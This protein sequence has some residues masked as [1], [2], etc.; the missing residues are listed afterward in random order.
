V[1]PT[2]I[3]IGEDFGPS[4]SSIPIP[5]ASARSR[6]GGL[7]QSLAW[8]AFAWCRRDRLRPTRAADRHRPVSISECAA[9]TRS[10]WCA[11]RSIGARWPLRR[12]DLQIHR[13]F[14]RR[15]MRADGGDVD[16]FS[17]YR[18]G[19]LS[20][21]A[22]DQRLEVF[23]GTTEMRPLLALNERVPAARQSRG[24]D[25]DFLRARSARHHRRGMSDMARR[26]ASPLPARATLPTWD[27]T[28]VYPHDA[29]KAKALW[30]QRAMRTVLP[31]AEAAPP[32]YARRGGEIVAA[33]TRAKSASMWPSKI[34]NGPMAGSGIHPARLRYEASW[35]CGPMTTTSSAR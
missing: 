30:R 34:W 12:S 3:A 26:S 17:N 18:P 14:H 20:S 33:R 16:A 9:A 28:G 4:T 29:A 5:C 6:S 1:N 25:G 11:M 27:L 32:S 7:L 13:R 8:G 35:P 21:I 23:A 10:L 19:E 31:H 22:A 15:P 2:E 24:A